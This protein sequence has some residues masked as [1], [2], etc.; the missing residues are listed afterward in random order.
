MTCH[1]TKHLQ[2]NYEV[3]I[4]ILKEDK[5]G[6]QQQ[7]A[8]SGAS[9]SSSSSGSEDSSTVFGQVALEEI[10]E[11]EESQSSSDGSQSDTRP[12]VIE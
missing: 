9:P 11:G 5:C 2:E 3:W 6:Q 7:A 4:N 10:V 8:A 12:R 1:Q